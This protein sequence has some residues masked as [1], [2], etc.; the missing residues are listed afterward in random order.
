[1]GMPGKSEI[2]VEE[3]TGLK[4]SGASKFIKLL[5]DNGIIGTVE[6]HGKGKYRFL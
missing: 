1:M 3:V 6:G 5:Y 2:I 4:P